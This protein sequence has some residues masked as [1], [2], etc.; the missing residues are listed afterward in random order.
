MAGGGGVGRW[1]GGRDAS[2]QTKIKGGHAAAPPSD[3]QRGSVKRLQLDGFAMTDSTPRQGLTAL[4]APGGEDE[5]V[6]P[7]HLSVL[8]WFES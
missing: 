7:P 5:R 1:R 4:R 8:P 2:L 6:R 3:G